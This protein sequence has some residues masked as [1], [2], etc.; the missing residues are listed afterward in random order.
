MRKIYHANSNQK[1]AGLAI[2]ILHK[3]DLKIK[4]VTRHLKGHFEMIKWSIRQE[5]VTI[6]NV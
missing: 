6:I 2:L 4:I 1:G 3:R 5:D